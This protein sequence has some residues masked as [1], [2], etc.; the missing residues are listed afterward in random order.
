MKI[1][2]VQKLVG[3]DE[4]VLA[5]LVGD[6]ESFVWAISQDRISWQRLA[7]GETALG[8]KVVR[9]RKGLDIIQLQKGA[10][11]GKVELFD[12]KLAHELYTELLGPV[13]HAL[14]GKRNV[15]VVPSGPLTS[16]PFHLLVTEPPA[17]PITDLKQIPDYSSA[18]WIINRH[19]ITMLPS[20]SSLKALR[21]LTKRPGGVKPLVG[22]GD[23]AFGAS[24]PPADSPAPRKP[25]T[26]R[27]S[28]V[29]TAYWK[30]GTIDSGS[31]G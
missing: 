10:A 16:L 29:Y 6:N 12:L 27:S 3:A 30:G 15:L 23:P 19:A 28:R 25:A 26:P 11:A 24:S 13:A 7:L 18:S 4:A 1:A 21:E 2:E 14:E 9:L 22:Y 17:N 20:V 8:E 5:F 31:P